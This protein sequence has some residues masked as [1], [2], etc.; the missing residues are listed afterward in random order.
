VETPQ[1]FVERWP[2][3]ERRLHRVLISMRVP[4]AWHDDVVQETSITMYRLWDKLDHSRPI[5]PFV[6]VVAERVAIAEGRRYSKVESRSEVPDEADIDAE[7]LAL[8]RV[9]IERVR[10]ALTSLSRR[11]REI[12]LAEINEAPRPELRSSALKMTRMRARKRLREFLGD[13]GAIFSVIPSLR[14]TISRLWTRP[15]TQ[16]AARPEWMAALVAGTNI[17]IAVVIGGAQLFVPPVDVIDRFGDPLASPRAT[18]VSALAQD[19]GGRVSTG[20]HVSRE[21]DSPPVGTADRRDRGEMAAGAGAGA[22]GSHAMVSH[23]D[24]TTRI[25]ICADVEPHPTVSDECEGDHT[26]LVAVGHPHEVRR[27][28][29]TVRKVL[30]DL[31]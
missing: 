11:D 27:V 16:V 25:E 26:A 21:G 6:R 7:T 1:S 8:W 22:L 5:W 15:T 20:S 3:L 29:A 24:D 18:L 14:S 30:N 4:D 12:L 31:P 9:D 17:L 19:E 13:G 2:A 23:E 28:G 10:T